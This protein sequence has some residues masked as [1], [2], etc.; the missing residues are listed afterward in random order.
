MSQ[1]PHDNLCYLDP[2]AAMGPIE[3]LPPEQQVVVHEVNRRVAA[4]QSLEQLIDYL[5][6]ATR[7]LL[8]TDRLSVAFVEEDGR[9]LVAD[10]T[11]TTYSSLHLKPGYAEDLAGSSLQRVIERGQPRIID[12]LSAYLENHPQSI[13]TRLVVA[14]GLRSS[15]SCPLVVEG[16]RVGVLF[17]SS[18]QPGAYTTQHITLHKAITERLSQ[19][20]EKTYRIRQLDRANRAYTEMLAFVT[21]E[22]KSPIAG[23]ISQARLLSEG[24]LGELSDKQRDVIGRMVG[25]GEHLMTLVREYLDLARIEGGEL[26]LDRRS[27]VDFVGEVIQPSI[28]QIEPQRA[29]RKMKI[30]TESAESLPPVSCDVNLMK[31][32]MVNLLSNAIKYGREGGRIRISITNNPDKNNS[33]QRESSSH[34]MLRVSVWNEGEGFSTSQQNKLFKR[35][36]R[37]DGS[38]SKK[39]R[40]TGVGLY[41][42]WRIIQAHNGRVRARSEPGEW[43]EFY[44]HL[45]IDRSSK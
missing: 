6:E 45:P 26:Q 37:L 1:N 28:E 22:L 9:R 41:T 17:R 39:Q 27:D 10:I 14:E 11:R 18:T 21:H 4:A 2:R 7:S 38:S 42:V 44:F 43:A 32:V 12:D 36:S 15:M 13:S 8:P 33:S 35:F 5:F 16:R 25:Q 24:Y 30:E 31:I 20:V 29:E 23:M 34:P 19:A 3:Q 40:G